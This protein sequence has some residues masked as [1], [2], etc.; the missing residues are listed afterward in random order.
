MTGSIVSACRGMG[1]AFR[2][3]TVL[4]LPARDRPM[5]R[6]REERRWA[7]AFFPLVGLA[8]GAGVAIV[9]ATPAPP[10]PRAAVAL[11]VWLAVS[12]G[13]HEDGWMDALDAAFAPVGRER[14]L[15]ILKDP[16]VGA[17]GATGG[18]LLQVLRFGALAVVSPMAALVAAVIGRWAMVLSLAYAPAARE[19]GLG[20]DFADR[21]RWIWASLV[22]IAILGP[23]SVWAGVGRITLAVAVAG[24]IA[25]PWTRFLVG[26]FGGLTGDGHGAV[27]VLAELGALYAFVP[28]GLPWMPPTDAFPL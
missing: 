19:A 21:P 2:L 24:I 5:S 15:E 6:L 17:H 11:L 13:L 20:A 27:G 4:P 26:R 1:I 7:V 16:R 28:M 10:L 25:V 22:A 3:L 12:G 8:V 18:T 14:R 9:L 23:L